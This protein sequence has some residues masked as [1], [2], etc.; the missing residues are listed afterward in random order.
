MGNPSMRK[1]VRRAQ[2]GE[3]GIDSSPSTY[4]GI[5]LKSFYFCTLTIIAA[6]ASAL[7]FR[8][9]IAIESEKLLTAILIASGVCAALMLVLSLVV[10]FIP[11]TVKIAGS[12][13]A[14]LEGAFLGLIVY[15]MDTMFPG[16]AFAA[17]LG[18]VIVFV[19][20]VAL[21]RVLNVRVSSKVWR[22]LLVAFLSL[23]VVELA[24]V[25]YAFAS[26]RSETFFQ[27]Y[28]WVQLA[29]S[30]FCVIYASV[31]LMWDLQSASYI[32]EAGADKSFEWQVA[33]S[34]VTTL[35]YLYIEILELIVR[36][37][38]LFGKNNK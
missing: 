31:L 14:V 1:L 36:F 38:M 9:A 23:L 3:V 6:V 10:A 11:K 8:Y 37:A 32:V 18:T 24:M 33:F 29:A 28:F 22:V 16:V 21:N 27:V 15:F 4:G 20:S 34:L 17:V 7:L 13:F 19:I 12:L 25:V 2:N 26:H 35:V 5:A 30:A